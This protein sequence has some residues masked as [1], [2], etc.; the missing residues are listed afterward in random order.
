[1]YRQWDALPEPMTSETVEQG[2]TFLGYFVMIDPARPEAKQ[3]VAVSHH[4]GIHTVM[5]TGDHKDTALAIAK[6]LGIWQPGDHC[7]TGVELAKLSDRELEDI[8]LNTTVYA[9]VSPEDKL[10]IV[11]AL[12][13]KGQVVAMTGDGVNDAPALKRADIGCAMG[14]TGTEVSKEAS[15]MVLL[16]DNFATIVNAVEEGR[17]I[18]NNIR[19]AIYYLLS[20]NVSEIMAIFEAILVGLG[21]PLTPVQILWMNLATDGLPALALGVEPPEKDI[22][23][24]PPRDSKEGVFAGGV[25]LKIIIQGVMMGILALSAYWLALFWGRSLVEAHTMAFLTMS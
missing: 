16:D 19:K 7:L 14:I 22:M 10:R 9:R 25:A 3:A 6:D 24:R 21:R 1:A 4:A 17:T 15:D 12:K 23:N 18:Y 5:I 13:A 2:L 8:V 11:D 20:C